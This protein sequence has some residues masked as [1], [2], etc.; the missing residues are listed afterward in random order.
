MPATAVAQNHL[1]IKEYEY[2]NA[3]IPSFDIPYDSS[4]EP[5][6]L[7]YKPTNNSDFEGWRL[8]DNMIIDVEVIPYFEKGEELSTG[9]LMLRVIYN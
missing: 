4:V 2:I 9:R 1:T 7:K 3:P 8:N 6:P 5:E